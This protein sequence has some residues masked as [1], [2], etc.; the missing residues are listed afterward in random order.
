[1]EEQVEL[2][3]ASVVLGLTRRRK[4]PT[5][6][7]PSVPGPDWGLRPGGS[8]EGDVKAGLSCQIPQTLNS[9]HLSHSTS[10]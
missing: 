10:P 3:E 2:E 7:P 9:G 5:P 4:A 6:P 8:F 1:M